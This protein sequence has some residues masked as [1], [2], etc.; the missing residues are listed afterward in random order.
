MSELLSSTHHKIKAE[1]TKNCKNE[2]FDDSSKL[3]II[4]DKTNVKKVPEKIEILEQVVLKTGHKSV[5]CH[6]CDKNVDKLL[7]KEHNQLHEQTFFSCSFTNCDKKFRRKSS[8]RKHSYLHKGKFKYKCDDCD[9]KFID[10]TKFE[11]HKNTKHKTKDSTTWTCQEPNCGK[12]FASPDYLKR[13]QVTHSGK[14]IRKN[15]LKINKL[16]I[17]CCRR[18]QI[19]M[20]G[21]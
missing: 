19:Q 11:L 6:Y 17:Y 4:E 1:W 8:L 20:H 15:G 18:L 3:E 16:M 12:S 14:K 2:I 5:K 10:L 13:H 7:L 9:I 21:L